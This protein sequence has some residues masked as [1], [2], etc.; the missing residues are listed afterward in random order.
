MVCAFGP[1]GNSLYGGTAQRL[2]N[3]QHG[4]AVGHG[5]TRTGS[6]GPGG[7]RSTG[8]LRRGRATGEGPFSSNIGRIVHSDYRSKHCTSRRGIVLRGPREEIREEMRRLLLLELIRAGKVPYGKAAKLLGIGQA[9]FLQYMAPHKIPSFQ[10][11]PG[12]TR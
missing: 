2:G 7:C 8:A 12:G 11:T 5:T 9:E 6:L 3:A 10:F 1:R 4:D